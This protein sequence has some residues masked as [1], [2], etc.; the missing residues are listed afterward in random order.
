MKVDV[1]GGA[2]MASPR[3]A[4][5]AV[6]SDPSGIDENLHAFADGVTEHDNFGSN[7]YDECLWFRLL[8]ETPTRRRAFLQALLRHR[9]PD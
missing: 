4:A 8:V 3:V 1:C 6:S 5:K 9:R 2:R 7:T